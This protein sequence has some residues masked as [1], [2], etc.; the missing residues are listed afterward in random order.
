MTNPPTLSVIVPCYNIESYVP[1]TVTSLVNNERD[2]FEFIFVE[3]RSTKD[4]TYEALLTLTKRLKNSRVIRHEKNGG[5]ATARN[6][7]IDASE[8]RYITFLDGDDWLAPGYLADLTDAIERLDVDFVRTDHVQVTGIERTVHRAPE[9]RRHVALDPRTSILPVD[10]TTMVDYPYAWAGVYH[11]RLLDKGML[12]FHDGLKTAEDRPWIWDLHRRADSYAVA[13]LRGV[14]Y[15]RG[16]A[17]SLTQIGDVRQLDFFRSFDLVLA[18]LADD[19]EVSRLRKKAL[20]N[21]C[22][23]IAHQ[24]LSR[25]RFERSIAARLKQMAAEALGRMSEDELEEALVGMGEERVYMLRRIRGG[26]K[27]VAA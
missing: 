17:S 23:V 25:G 15:R 11:R 3:D 6:T 2:D 22:V 8:A 5:L 14:F 21:Y 13:S 19:P 12:R 20:R 18:E 27:G 4:K 24:L 26:M 16:V 9:G 10:D 7:G 1:E